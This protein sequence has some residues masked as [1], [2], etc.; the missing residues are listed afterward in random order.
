M[1]IRVWC[2]FDVTD[3]LIKGGNLENDMHIGRTA[4]EDKGRD[5]DDASTSQGMPKLAGKPPTA[6][7]E[8]WNRFSHGP[9]REQPWQYFISDFQQAEL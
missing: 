3:L 4:C 2:Q 6:W 1:V 9:H 5:W 8:A 7:Q